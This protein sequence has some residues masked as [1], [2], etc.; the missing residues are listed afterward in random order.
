MAYA[1]DNPVGSTIVLITGDRDFAYALSILSLRRY[2]VVLIAG[3][4]A[5]SSL[6]MQA[7]IR[8]DWVDDI[9]RLSAASSFQPSPK[10]CQ[11]AST[12]EGKRS[13]ALTPDSS[14]IPA[15]D[16]VDSPQSRNGAQ[17][18][19]ASSQFHAAQSTRQLYRQERELLPTTTTNANVAAP[20]LPPRD[21]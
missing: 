7:D 18:P 19:L 1:I 8:Y 5:R 10:S 21:S 4:N 14:C 11:H 20:L 2:K 16:S 12:L 17:R 13:D 3:S 6:T 15:M 9:V